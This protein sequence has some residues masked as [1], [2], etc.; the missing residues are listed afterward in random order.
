MKARKKP[1]EVFAVKY[2]HTIILDE[3]LKLLRTNGKEP[4]R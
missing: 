3:F 2:D 1:I 4:V